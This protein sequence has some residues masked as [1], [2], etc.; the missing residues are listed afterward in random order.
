MINIKELNAS[1]FHE[2]EQNLNC[3]VK[4]VCITAFSVQR[5]R[6]SLWPLASGDR[7]P[8]SGLVTMVA[9][10]GIIPGNG[11]RCGNPR[12]GAA[13]LQLRGLGRL[14]NVRKCYEMYFCKN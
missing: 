1:C 13:R 7:S 5:M 8:S 4:I 6:P 9:A 11:P 10:V 2:M 12:L 3:D 14:G